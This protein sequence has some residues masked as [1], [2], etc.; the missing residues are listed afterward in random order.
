[1]D[2]FVNFANRSLH[3]CVEHESKAIRAAWSVQ[4]VRQKGFTHCPG[5]RASKQRF[6]ISIDRRGWWDVQQGLVDGMNA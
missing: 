1:M 6:E 5:G 2:V 3:K 4:V